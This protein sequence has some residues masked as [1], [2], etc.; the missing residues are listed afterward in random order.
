MSVYESLRSPFREACTDRTLRSDTSP[1]YIS[2][3]T[4]TGPASFTTSAWINVREP[5]TPPAMTTVRL[6]PSSDSLVRTWDAPYDTVRL[7]HSYDI[8]PVSGSTDAI[9]WRTVTVDLPESEMM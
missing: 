1:P 3:V 5:R 7:S 6:S 8:S 4:S 2:N 9:L